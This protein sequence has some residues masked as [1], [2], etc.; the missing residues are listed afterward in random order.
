M[1]GMERCW[2]KV[3][4]VVCMH[5]VYVTLQEQRGARSWKGFWG[6]QLL[7]TEGGQVLLQ[8]GLPR[9]QKSALDKGS[10]GNEAAKGINR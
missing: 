10:P 4:R 6:R 1:A 7:A 2:R 3:V 5:L 9:G 8:P